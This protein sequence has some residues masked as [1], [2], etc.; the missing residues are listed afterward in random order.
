M[1]RINALATFLNVEKT[2]I[3]RATGYAP[4]FVHHDCEF[5]VLTDAEATQMAED[6]LLAEL[7]SD[8][9]LES[10]AHPKQFVREVVQESDRARYLACDAEEHTECGF[11]IYRLN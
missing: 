1:T 6:T 9:L 4:I 10:I 7:E 3:E 11:Y 2:H 8:G 5:F